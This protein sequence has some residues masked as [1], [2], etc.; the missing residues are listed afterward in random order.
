MDKIPMHAEAVGGL[1]G[2]H[3]RR[4]V[5]G[6]GA[7]ALAAFL[8][9]CS[10]GGGASSTGGGGGSGPTPDPTGSVTSATVTGCPNG[11]TGTCY[12]LNITCPS[13]AEMDGVTLNV[14]APS[15]T[16]IGTI[17]LSVGGGGDN[18]YE[19]NFT[20]G[21]T[22][23]NDLISA[24]FTTVQISFTGTINGATQ[25][26][27]WLTGPGGVRKLACRY[28]TAA[29][30]VYQNIHMANTGAP[31]CATGNSGGSAMIGYA[32]AH[33][34]LGSIFAMVQPTSGPPMGRIDHGCICNQPPVSTAPTA[35]PNPPTLPECYG[36]AAADGILNSAYGSPICTGSATDTT[37]A[38]L[39]LNDSVASPDAN[40]SYPK[41]AVHFIYGGMDTTA[42]VPQG[43]DWATIILTNHTIA[44]AAGSTHEIANDSS[45]ASQIATDL[46]Q[47]CKLQ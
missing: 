29:Q 46:I 39:F 23:V 11:L 40:L 33:Y 17:L 44:C 30:W 16:P 20:Y 41:T 22:M 7:A 10:G 47:S 18:F 37:N 5:L 13:I 36:N 34:G 14:K 24:G 21:A 28:A 25:T 2:R 38:T 43:L 26:E 15:G 12:S 45:G 27:G 1:F 19:D 32:M 8:A 35:C 42:A 9:A 6:F 31:F 3:A 4:L